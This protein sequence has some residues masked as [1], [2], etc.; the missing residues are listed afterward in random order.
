MDAA[1]TAGPIKHL[2][3]GWALFSFHGRVAHYWREDASTMRP[4]IGEYGRVRWYVSLCGQTGVVYDRIPALH[5]GNWSQCKKCSV[6][7]RRLR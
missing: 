7:A 2:T 3:K 4:E 6:K 5:P 1:I